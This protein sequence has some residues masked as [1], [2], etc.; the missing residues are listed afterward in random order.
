MA[1]GTDKFRNT[2]TKLQES[3]VTCILKFS[4][5]R[6]RGPLQIIVAN[7]KHEVVG[8]VLMDAT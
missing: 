4:R 3:S 2:T 5:Y 7:K 8:L 1:I 6:L